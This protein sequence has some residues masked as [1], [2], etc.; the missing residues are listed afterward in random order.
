[1]KT[2]LS[3]LAPA[4]LSKH[5]VP[6]DALQGTV[7]FLNATLSDPKQRSRHQQSFL[8]GLGF[9]L[10]HK[11]ELNLEQA[12]HL[13][14]ICKKSG[15]TSAQVL[16]SHGIVTIN[17]CDQGN[18]YWPSNYSGKPFEAMALVELPALMAA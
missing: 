2:S 16:Y 6:R 14:A 12:Q 11:A 4:D 17:L 15:W 7:D 13:L 18:L 1:M 8:P 5:M 3:I 9:S 10:Q